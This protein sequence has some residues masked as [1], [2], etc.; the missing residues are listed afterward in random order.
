MEFDY[1]T[2]IFNQ[3]SL[4]LDFLNMIY[5]IVKKK[6]T[7]GVLYLTKAP[8]FVPATPTPN[9][10]INENVIQYRRKGS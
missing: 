3:P 2:K 6:G 1:F 10:K 7:R 8:K 9:A 5:I 4:I